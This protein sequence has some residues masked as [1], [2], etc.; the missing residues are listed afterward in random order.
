MQTRRY[1]SH[2]AAGCLGTASG[3]L[4]QVR[5]VGT[6]HQLSKCFI[7]LPWMLQRDEWHRHSA[8]LT[9]LDFQRNTSAPAPD[10]QHPM[11]VDGLLQAPP[12]EESGS[13]FNCQEGG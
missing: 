6:W 10:R 2:S 5:S 3:A 1:E 7:R 12:L 11:R 4:S 13:I 8:R 9:E